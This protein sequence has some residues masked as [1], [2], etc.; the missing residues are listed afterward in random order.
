[1]TSSYPSYPSA[2]GRFTARCGPGYVRLELSPDLP[3]SG[4]LL[5]E[6][7]KEIL[8]LDGDAYVGFGTQEEPCVG[9]VLPGATA[10]Q[11]RDIATKQLFPVAL[12]P[13][14]RW[15]EARYLY[16]G[17]AFIDPTL[18]LPAARFVRPVADTRYLPRWL[19]LSLKD[20]QPVYTVH[21]H[22]R[23]GMGVADR[24]VFLRCTIGNPKYKSTGKATGVIRD[25]KL[26]FQVCGHRTA[27]ALWSMPEASLKPGVIHADEFGF[28]ACISANNAQPT[29]EIWGWTARLCLRQ[30]FHP[31]GP[32][33]LY[34]TPREKVTYINPPLCG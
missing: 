30:G 18:T 14:Q 23:Q 26:V 3:V 9:Y 32:F 34:R 2:N 16:D 24:E 8:K 15:L 7:R 28:V 4:A 21:S 13:P 22:S 19:Q 25:G 29:E 1:V 6:W 31:V 11:A 33:V 17:K 20:G 27:E 10:A 12:L 5:R